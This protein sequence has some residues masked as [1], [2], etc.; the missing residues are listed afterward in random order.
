MY[1]EPGAGSEQWLAI[2]HEHDVQFLI[3]NR[4]RDAELL[5]LVESSH[6]WEVE[7]AGR[8]SMIF[9]QAGIAPGVPR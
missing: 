9:T 6:K 1:D 4:R 8:D 5:R 3:L 2:L 7:W